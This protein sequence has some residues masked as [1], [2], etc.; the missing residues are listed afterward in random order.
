M[1]D[2][3]RQRILDAAQQLFVESGADGVSM[4]KVAELAGVSAPAIYRHYENKDDLLQEIIEIGLRTLD[5]YLQP[6]LDASTPLER[7]ER[8][9]ERFLDFSIEQPRYFEFAFMIPSRSIADMRTELNERNWVT[10]NLALEQ[11]GACMEAGI[12][13]KDD[14]L[15]AAITIWSGVYGLVALHRMHRFG[16]DDELF[17][18]IYRASVERLLNGLKP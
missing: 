17:R 6:A 12:F 1:S 8:L 7:L 9:A 15:G 18:Q 13:K 4:R 16:P 11:I 2:D 5:T 14:P 10:F 3:L